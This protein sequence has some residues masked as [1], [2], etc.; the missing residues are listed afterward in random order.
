MPYPQ[1]K[2]IQSQRIE[3]RCPRCRL[4]LAVESEGRLDVRVKNECHFIV[5][6]GTLIATCRR[7]SEMWEIVPK[8]RDGPIT[9]KLK[10]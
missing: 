1:V 9:A 6:G 2:V 5:L 3:H 7:C 10:G 8:T 4:L